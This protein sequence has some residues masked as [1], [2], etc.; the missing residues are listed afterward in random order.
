MNTYPRG[1]AADIQL[2]DLYGN[3]NKLSV[4]DGGSSVTFGIDLRR[5]GMR[6]SAGVTI[7]ASELIHVRDMLDR[8]LSRVELE[9]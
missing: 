5:H 1:R 7:A 9:D 3:E 2:P 4:I 8:V 6:V